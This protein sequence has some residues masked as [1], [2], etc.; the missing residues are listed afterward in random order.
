VDPKQHFTQPQ[1][2][3]TEAS[4]VKEL[5]KEGIGRPST[6][7]T[8]LNTIRARSY[9]T[10]EKKRFV[11]T[12]LGMVV[13]EMLVKN[14]PEIM[15]PKFTATMEQ[16]LDKIADGELERDKLLRDF[17]A[18]FKKDLTAFGGKDAGKKAVETDIM[19]PQCG[20]HKLAIRFSKA[21]EFLGCTGYPECT[22][23]SNFA[24]DEK[25]TIEL[26]EAEAPKLMEQRCPLCG[27]PLRQ[28]KGKFG[29]FIACSGYPEC[30]YVE[31]KKLPFP[32]PQSGGDIIERAWRGG[33]FWG[34]SDY[35]KCKLA[36][37]DAIEE[38]PCPQCKWPFLTK[39]TGKDGVTTLL[40]A[41]KDCNYKA[42]Q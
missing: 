42:E 31:R 13:T 5:E 32:C 36:I 39:K 10:L 2:R 30:K 18:T 41:N 38:M 15:N 7:A 35:P 3:F 23:T 1:P 40:C 28:L 14:L 8:I 21:G 9:T 24:R 25:G 34:C 12:E 27:K 22:F 29:D 6:Y 17:Y 37:F 19:C 33:K 20:K 26:K 4:L 11:P 16:D